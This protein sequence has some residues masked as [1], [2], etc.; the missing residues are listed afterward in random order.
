MQYRLNYKS[1]LIAMALLICAGVARADDVVR[2]FPGMPEFPTFDQTCGSDSDCQVA[3]HQIDCCGSR[4]GLGI[5]INEGARFDDDEAICRRQYPA[6]DCVDRGI[7][8][9]DG[10]SAYYE[11]DV[12]VT[13]NEGT[14]TTF[15][16]DE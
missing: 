13:C 5:N 8:T 9:D 1:G 3:V 14:C 11:A 4:A 7:L 15:V 6:C 12:G 2:C 16:I 10:Q